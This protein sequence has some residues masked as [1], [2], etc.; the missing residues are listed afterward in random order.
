MRRPQEHSLARLLLPASLGIWGLSGAVPAAEN[1]RGRQPLAD[2]AIIK[3]EG[4]AQKESLASVKEPRA[5]DPE[6]LDQAIIKSANAL[7]EERLAAVK[8][9][10]GFSS[11][12]AVDALSAAC[13]DKD[14]QV[15]RFAL[16]S[17][18]KIGDAKGLDAAKAC[19]AD[20][21]SMV[22][23]EAANTI[24][25]L[26][27]NHKESVW[28]ELLDKTEDPRVRAEA[29]SRLSDMDP[30]AIAGQIRAASRQQDATL[31]QGA[32]KGLARLGQV[33]DSERLRQMAG[34]KDTTV[35]LAV[36]N[37]CKCMPDKR[38]AL[39]MLGTLSFDQDQGVR[40]C[41]AECLA[42]VDDPGAAPLFV[43][44]LMKEPSESLRTFAAQQIA[45]T[46]NAASFRRQMQAALEQEKNP[47]VRQAIQTTLLAMA[48]E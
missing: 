39:E 13:R 34:D 12:K 15:R 24:G 46:K 45:K 17:L 21:Y 10:G 28:K 26:A 48:P 40:R 27:G 35:R 36:A 42:A 19:L 37:A 29:I 25:V 20:K 8:A 38:L 2:Q 1:D 33:E 31:R 44:I 41:S 7:P 6:K 43:E 22:R 5:L 32:A 23:E 11:G 3:A 30:T 18:A 47:K 9:L 4:T 16:R 14:F